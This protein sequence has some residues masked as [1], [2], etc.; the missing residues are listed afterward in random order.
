M[1]SFKV[2][3]KETAQMKSAELLDN[4]EKA[5]GFIPNLLGVFAESP[6]ALKAY[7]TIG[8]IFDESSLSPTE[9]QVVILTASRFNECHYC[10]A[11]HTVVASMQ[12]VQ[13]DVVEAIRNDQPIADNRLQALRVFTTAIVEKRGWVSD[14]DITAFLAAGYN[15]AQILEVILGISFKTLSNY[16]NHIADTPLDDA[17]SRK[18]WMPVLERMAS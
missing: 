4:A 6:A 16:T 5:F 9:R 17:F 11:A 7:L 15:N 18:A 1:N 2:H 12:K 10:I 13:S 14:D 3:T 8:H